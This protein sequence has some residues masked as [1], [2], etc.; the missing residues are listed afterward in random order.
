LLYPVLGGMAFLVA[1]G[2]LTVS[3]GMG[4][5]PPELGAWAAPIFFTLSA[6]TILVYTEA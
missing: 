3:A 4:M 2:V 6:L 1:D 5:I